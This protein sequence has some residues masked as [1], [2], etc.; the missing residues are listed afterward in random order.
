[1]Q[2]HTFKQRAALLAGCSLAAFASMAAM[3]LAAQAQQAQPAAV[4]TAPAPAAG[5][6]VAAAAKSKALRAHAARKRHPTAKVRLA[7]TAVRVAQLPPPPKPAGETQGPATDITDKQPTAE[8]ETV[9]VQGYRKAL[10]SALNRKRNSNLQIESVAPEDVG[11]LPDTNVAEV[12]ATP[13]RRADRPRPCG[14]GHGRA[15][16]RLA[17]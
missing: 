10:E 3:P 8:P 2:V 15:H 17:L 9:I 5:T 1:M 6:A 4:S 13:A 12:S 7:A 14:R 11:K 16:R